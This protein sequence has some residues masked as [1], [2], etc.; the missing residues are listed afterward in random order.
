[1]KLKQIKISNMMSFP[2]VADMDTME[3]IILD[4]E[5]NSLNMNILI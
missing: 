3:G 2:Y 4:N 5:K 1:M